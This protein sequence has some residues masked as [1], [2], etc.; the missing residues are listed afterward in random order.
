MMPYSLASHLLKQFLYGDHPSGQLSYMPVRGR[1]LRLHAME[2]QREELGRSIE[3][4]K[5]HL[6]WGEKVI[7]SFTPAQAAE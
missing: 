4:I 5:E 7:S 2:L 1:Y 3:E 6:K